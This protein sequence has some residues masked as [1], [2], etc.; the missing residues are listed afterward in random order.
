MEGEPCESRNNRDR[1]SSPG[2][3][4]VWLRATARTAGGR[5]YA[6]RRGQ[7]RPRKDGSGPF[8][9]APPLGASES[10]SDDGE[11]ET[12]TN[13]SAGSA[14]ESVAAIRGVGG[15][16]GISP[17]A[18]VAPPSFSGPQRRRAE[19]I[20]RMERGT[21]EE[22]L[23]NIDQGLLS[24]EDVRQRAANLKGEL[25]GKLKLGVYVLREVVRTMAA[26]ASEGGDPG[27]WREKVLSLERDMEVLKAEN[28]RLQRR[29]RKQQAE[30]ANLRAGERPD[31]PVEGGAPSS[32]DDAGGTAMEVVGSGGIP[33]LLHPPG[34]PSL[35]ENLAGIAKT[36]VGFGERLRG[37]S[38][39][40]YSSSGPCLS[41]PPSAS[42]WGSCSGRG[43]GRRRKRRG[44]GR[45]GGRSFVGLVV[46]LPSPRRGLPPIS[47]ILHWRGMLR[48]QWVNGPP[49]IGAIRG[50]EGL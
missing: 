18:E 2:T 43:G 34:D 40:A 36:L 16:A 7:G 31:S 15:P 28:G 44:E 8:K 5:L 33:P 17:F 37:K 21:T 1:R 29:T 20:R 49:L 24:I 45:P 14:L 4:A 35:A 47:R 32:T 3:D 11:R 23:K 50:R 46:H 26:R 19:E 6:L 22:M 41:P 9:P 12:R 10:D 27:Y 42:H 30:L 48:Q 38:G 25:S 39:W 13:T